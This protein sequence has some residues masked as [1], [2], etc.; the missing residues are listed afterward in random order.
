VS[1]AEG[2][3]RRVLVAGVGNVF[4]TDDGFGVE[5]A[6]RLA[7]RAL[8]EGVDVADYGIRGVH[9]AYEL[10]DGRYDTLI[11][12]DAVPIEGPPG[13]LAVIDAGC[14]DDADPGADADSAPHDPLGI[15]AVDGHGMHP[16]AVLRLLRRL[17]GELDRVLVVGCK[18]AGVAE[19]MDLSPPVAAAVDEAV[20]LVTDLVTDLVDVKGDKAHA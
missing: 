12:V 5:V 7:I 2:G 13:T 11:M 14:V 18:P 9:L 3:A 8:P 19:G 6:R 1:G 17:G 15:P 4:L 10:L 20:R 16:M